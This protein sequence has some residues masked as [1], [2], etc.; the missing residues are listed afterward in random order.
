M[1]NGLIFR[2]K[3]FGIKWYIEHIVAFSVVRNTAKQLK[4]AHINR[5]TCIKTTFNLNSFGFLACTGPYKFSCRLL[6]F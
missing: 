3:L 5:K 2:R 4:N 6:T 1:I